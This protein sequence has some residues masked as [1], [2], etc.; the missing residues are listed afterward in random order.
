LAA[1]SVRNIFAMI[2]FSEL[3][4][5]KVHAFLEGLIR[6]LLQHCSDALPNRSKEIVEVYR[7]LGLL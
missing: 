5:K 2:Q 7:S 6:Y 3:Q 4:L 1:E